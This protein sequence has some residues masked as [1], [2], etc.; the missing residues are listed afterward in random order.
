MRV[1]FCVCACHTFFHTLLDHAL[2]DGR[3]ALA[4]RQSM[5]VLVPVQGLGQVQQRPRGVHAGR[6]DEN[7]WSGTG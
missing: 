6:Q 3:L 7:E 5:E 2:G 1:Y 4:Q